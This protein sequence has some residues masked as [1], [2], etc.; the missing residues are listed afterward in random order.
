MNTI[1]A[2]NGFRVPAHKKGPLDTF[3][4]IRDKEGY[5]LNYDGNRSACVH[6]WDRFHDELYPWLRK[7]FAMGDKYVVVSKP[8]PLPS[9]PAPNPPPKS[10]PDQDKKTK[11]LSTSTPPPDQKQITK[12]VAV[13]QSDPKSKGSSRFRIPPIPPKIPVLGEPPT[14]GIKPIL[15]Q[16]TGRDAIFALACNYPLEL[17]QFFVGSLR[18]FNYKDDIVLAV[19]PPKQMHGG[20]YDYLKQT[21]VVAYGFEVDCKG[22]DDCK[23]KDEFLG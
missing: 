18:R 5:I 7:T 23:L 11:S 3:W 19:S 10:S 4:K 20:V 16:H 8:D 14:N 12:T 1:G 21:N 17:Y 22:K 13:P 2:M 9:T 6:Q 15:G